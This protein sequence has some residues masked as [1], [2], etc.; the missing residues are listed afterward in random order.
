M[1]FEENN[2][3]K[4]RFNPYRFDNVILTNTN[5]PNE[6]IFNNLSQE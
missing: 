5:D 6:N 4:L 2:F 1:S 3:E